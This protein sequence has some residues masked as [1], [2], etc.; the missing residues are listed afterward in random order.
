M[1]VMYGSPYPYLIFENIYSRIQCF[2]FVFEYVRL[3]IY[4]LV[5]LSCVYWCIYV[6][7][8]LYLISGVTTGGSED[9]SP[10]P[11]VLKVSAK[12]YNHLT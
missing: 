12:L 5:Y 9:Q 1:E 10:L 2:V 4:A 3:F 8:I 11:E 7:P 6:S